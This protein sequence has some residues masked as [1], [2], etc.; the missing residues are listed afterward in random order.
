MYYYLRLFNMEIQ[1]V[2]DKYNTIETLLI[3]HGDLNDN[4]IGSYYND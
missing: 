4:N 2:K 1:I 3:N